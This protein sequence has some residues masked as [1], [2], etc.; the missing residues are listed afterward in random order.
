M[1]QYFGPELDHIPQTAE[2]GRAAQ[3]PRYFPAQAQGKQSLTA[4]HPV[5]GP[6]A[7]NC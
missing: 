2:W 7:V 3:K 5:A 4:A 1:C 6:Q